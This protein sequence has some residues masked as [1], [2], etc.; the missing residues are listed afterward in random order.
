MPFHD[1]CAKMQRVLLNK[2]LA[3][4]AGECL[5]AK[6]ISNG[7]HVLIKR[8]VACNVGMG[9]VV[10]V[11]RRK[12]CRVFNV[13]QDAVKDVMILPRNGAFV[14]ICFTDWYIKHGWLR[15]H[16]G[17]C[18]IPGF[19]KKANAIILVLILMVVYQ[20]MIR[21]PCEIFGAV[22]RG[23]IYVCVLHFLMQQSLIGK[24]YFGKFL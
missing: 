4:L 8:L 10:H 17:A 14:F 18:N 22:W 2:R 3:N 5:V 1:G 6:N 23:D 13:K 12:V 7:L 24:C 16:V 11:V 21:D 19:Y 9:A 15:M 20:R